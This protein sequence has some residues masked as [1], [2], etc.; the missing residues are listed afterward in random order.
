MLVLRAGKKRG[1]GIKR[2]F[3]KEGPKSRVCSCKFNARHLKT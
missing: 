1:E 3:S 2:K